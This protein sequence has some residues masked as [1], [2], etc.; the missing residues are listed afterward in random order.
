MKG[1]NS[2]KNGMIIQV[3]IF[4]KYI[5]AANNPHIAKAPLSPI[6]ILAGKILKNINDAKTA[7]IITTNVVAMYVWFTNVTTDKTNNSIHINPPANQSN[8]SVIFMAFTMAIVIIN[9]K[10]GQK[11]HK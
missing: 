11:I 6:N 3:L 2:I 8:Q 10:I 1:K 4:N 7:Q 5:N 9:V